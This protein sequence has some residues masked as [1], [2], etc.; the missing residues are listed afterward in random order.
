MYVLNTGSRDAVTDLLASLKV[1]SSV[2]CLSELRAPWGFEVDGANVAKFHFVLEGSCW[3]RLDGHEPARLHAGD[4]VILSRGDRHAMG[5]RP[6]SPVLSLDHIVAGHPLD[7]DAR[8]NYG[9]TGPLTR[10]LCG[11]F[12][13]EA[14]VPAALIRWSSFEYWCVAE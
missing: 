2:Y 6:D 4:V 12:A 13:L 11:G 14:P 3:L 5:D 1:H 9:G 10:L 7:S 8:L